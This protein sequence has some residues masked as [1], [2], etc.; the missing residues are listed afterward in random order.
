MVP[1]SFNDKNP[2]SE[3]LK[4]FYEYH[5]ILMEPWDGPA[6]LLF[7]D[8]R[9][10]GGMLDRNGL[11]PARYTITKNDMMV[12]ASEVGVMDFDPSEVAEKGRLQ[13]GK[14]L[15]IDTQ[16]GKIY[17][18]GEIKER[19]AAQHPYR[20]WLNTNRIELEKLRSGRKVE[21][22]IENLTRKELEFGFGEEDID[23][24][25]IPMA[26]KGQEPTASMGNDTP[27]AV[28][29]DQPQIF[30]NYF[31]QQFAQVTN[32][33]I[34]SIREN[35]VMSLTEYI[36]RVGSGILNPDESNCKMVRLPHPILTNTQ[37][38]ILQNIRYKGFNT[39]KLHMVFET[40]KGEEGLHEALDEL[41]KQ[42]AQSV[43]DGYN[44]II[45]SDRD[46]D[47]T[48]AAIPSLLAVSA[49]HHYLC[50]LYTSDAA[51]E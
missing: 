49:V 12:V 42:A 32:P 7:S 34:D 30:F 51:D 6:A 13:P 14:I 36:G 27:L 33:A 4:A 41:C 11:R 40:A 9:Y 43:D 10:A 24:T 21:N 44:Y 16:E 31:R 3:D 22:A 47:A 19:L 45:L 46:V 18:D 28:L 25:I 39:V 35:L 37:L 17:Y 20:Q 2:I 50:L 15:L 38:D 5:S 48:H 29:S 1:E 26:T 8:G 23:G